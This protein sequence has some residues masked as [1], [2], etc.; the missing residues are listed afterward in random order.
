[1]PTAEAAP[2]NPDSFASIAPAMLPKVELRRR[3][4]AAR[5]AAHES[6]GAAGAAVRSHFLAA[7]PIVPGAV[8]AGY[9]PVGA[10][11]DPRPLMEHLA[12][13]GHALG[14]PVV[15]D[16]PQGLI[17]RH[18]APGLALE[19]GAHGI[20]VPPAS[21]WEIVP[22]LL[23]VPLLAFDRTGLRLGSGAGYY[24]RALARARAQR[25]VIAVGLAFAAQ[26][27]PSLPRE[28]HDQPLDWVVTERAAIR[29]G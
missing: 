26:E 20:P 17:F 14:L 10:E 19:S 25:P 27:Q 8:V 15:V 2:S 23:L 4:R 21:V 12:A 9:W 29:I 16:G 1:M 24:D 28:P 13:R 22:H 3:A 5:K 11:I 6:D 18:W 7:V